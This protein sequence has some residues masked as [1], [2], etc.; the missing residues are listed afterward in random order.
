LLPK[1][2]FG[3]LPGRSAPD[4]VHFIVNCI[5]NAWR[6]GR[7]VSILATDIQGA[8]PNMVIDLLLHRMRCRRVPTEIISY[9]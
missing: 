6:G 8:F 4:A 1:L 5:K 9:L 7:V 2:H 3:G